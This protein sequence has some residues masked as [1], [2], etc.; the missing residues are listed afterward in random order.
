MSVAAVVLLLA[1]LIIGGAI[2]GSLAMLSRLMT[3]TLRQY[4]TAHVPFEGAWSLLG[5][6]RIGLMTYR[7]LVRAGATRDGLYLKVPWQPP[8]FVPWSDLT[9][10]ERPGLLDIHVTL[11]AQRA[12]GTPITLTGGAARKL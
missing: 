6:V 4:Y 7:H 5:Y 9:A 12:P 8:V 3:L 2:V 1:L 10:S 11:R